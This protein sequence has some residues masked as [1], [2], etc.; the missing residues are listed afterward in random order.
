MNRAA[1]VSLLSSL[2]LLT[3]VAL[4]A[5]AADVTGTLSGDVFDQTG[6]PLKG[7]KLTA[8]SPTQIGGAR[9]AYSNEEG[10]F[11]LR[12]LTPGVFSLTASAPKL[13]SWRQ[14]GI[15]IRAGQATDVSVILEVA[16]AVEEVKVVQKAPLVSTSSASVRESYDLDYVADGF[17]AAPA[18]PP[19][20]PAGPA[21][22]PG[23]RLAPGDSE[24]YAHLDESPFLAARETPLSTFS[25]DV[26]T[27]SLR[28]R[29][30]LPRAGRAAAARTRCGSRS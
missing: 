14:V 8:T 11:S 4:P 20:A 17:A 13:Q 10:R 21:F 2:T 7:I 9:V 15:E 19:P 3:P 27:A 5:R 6:I 29:A 16:T 25:I 22:T 30:P 24:A 18:A 1:V 23:V 28:E 26:D 12:N